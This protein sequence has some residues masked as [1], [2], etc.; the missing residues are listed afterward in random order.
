MS[1]RRL[2]WV[3]PVVMLLVAAWHGWR[4]NEY[5]E[6]P[7]I[8]AGFGMFA[9]I[10]GPQRSVV[11]E[12]ADDG[13]VVQVPSYS[14]DELIRVSNIPT[15]TSLAGFLQDNPEWASIEVMRPVFDDDL[16]VTWELVRRVSIR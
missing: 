1:S 6:N 3:V 2:Y 13:E 8:G 7:W 4:V 12:S 16:G 14:S 5:D 15:E 9:E 10:D 11:L